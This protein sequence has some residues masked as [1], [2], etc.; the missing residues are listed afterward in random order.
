MR[1]PIAA[2][3]VPRVALAGAAAALALLVV[4]A[5]DSGL[6][7]D[8]RGGRGGAAAAVETAPESLARFPFDLGVTLRSPLGGAATLREATTRGTAIG[9]LGAVVFVAFVTEAAADDADGSGTPLDDSAPTDDNDADDCFVAVFAQGTRRDIAL[10]S[11]ANFGGAAASGASNEPSLAWEENGAF[12]PTQPSLTNPAGWLHVA[13]A[14]TATDL[15][16]TDRNGG[17]SDLFRVSLAANVVT[18]GNGQATLELV[19]EEAGLRAPQRLSV[20]DGQ[21]GT[22]NG[23]TNV[24]TSPRLTGSGDL[25]AFLAGDGDLDAGDANGAVDVFLRQLSSSTTQRM[26]AG[27]GDCSDVVLTEQALPVLAFASDATDLV[28]GDTNGVRD[29]FF[30]ALDPAVAPFVRD[31]WARANVTSGDAEAQGGDSRRPSVHVT[32][33]DVDGSNGPDGDGDG[34]FD[35]I[36]IAFESDATNLVAALPTPSTSNAYLH[37]LSD[38]SRTTLLLNQRVGPGGATLGSAQGGAA[39][40]DSF[41]PRLRPD[42][43]GV[44]FE[45]LADNLDVLRPVDA[46]GALDV[47]YAD[48]RLLPA[49]GLLRHWR[50]SVTEAGGDANGASSDALF[51]S[52]GAVEETAGVTPYFGRALGLFMQSDRCINCHRFNADGGLPGH[53]NSPNCDNCHSDVGDPGHLATWLAAPAA[54]DF[55]NKSLDELCAQVRDN[56]SLAGDVRTHLKEDGRIVWGLTDGNTPGGP[57][58][59]VLD[60]FGITRG[61]WDAFVDAWI[62]GGFQCQPFGAGNSD[63]VLFT[64]AATNLA[65]AA[66]GG[67]VVGFLDSAVNERLSKGSGFAPAGG[68]EAR[69]AAHSPSITRDDRFVAFVTA[70]PLDR[71]RDGNGVEDVYVRDLLLGTTTLASVA[72]GTGLA[73]DGASTRPSAAVGADGVL[74]VAF[75][76]V[77]TD[78]VAGFVDGDAG[79]SDIYVVDFAAFDG[80]DPA[81]LS[82]TLVSASLAAATQGGDAASSRPSLAVAGG[83]AHVA[84]ESVATDLLFGFTDGNG[85]GSD[86]FVASPVGAPL[87]LAS[88]APLAGLSFGGDG[89]SRAPALSDDALFVVYASEAS[90]VAVGFVDRNGSGADI[91]RAQVG[92]FSSELVSAAISAATDGADGDCAAPAVNEDGTVVAFESLASDLVA[93]FVDGNG[94]TAPDLFAVNFNNSPAPFL[95]SAALGSATNGG[96]GASRSASLTAAGSDVA[97][98]SE[99]T[100]LVASDGNLAVADLFV[101]DINAQA[102]ERLPTTLSGAPTRAPASAPRLGSNDG[103]IVFVTAADNLL[104]PSVDGNGVADVYRARR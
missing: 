90:D 62:D 69:L 19:R 53:T 91:Y 68:R 99:A 31:P 70:E 42:G 36:R 27:D 57:R 46:N 85:A 25:L 77:A 2:R 89:S 84:F 73:G 81:T 22:G 58:T 1:L 92:G 29:L 76:S 41:R 97:F 55:R 30:A 26:T 17:G 48:L 79:G 34:R 4:A 100:D 86:V 94:S 67:Q 32:A 65:S 66:T 5:C 88:F 39:A 43:N 16:G 7:N 59:T 101:R 10:A 63:Y 47:V 87:G 95:A 102:T 78:L 72:A 3:L 38:S 98:E 51:G 93:G 15:P 56:P 45:T 11:G 24:A 35:V 64:T 28:A 23:G 103:L 6:G 104:A 8:P 50:L 14:S 71:V 54:F 33:V 44:V 75:E 12:D 80:S 61:D 83:L 60:E 37:L 13:F 49:S 40:C 20:Q 21:A 82:T 96:N 18:G 52:T 74:Q 9:G